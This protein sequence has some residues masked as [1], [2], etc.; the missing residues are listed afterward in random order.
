M[1]IVVNVRCMGNGMGMEIIGN[2][3]TLILALR[4][5]S[6]HSLFIFVTDR[7]PHPTVYRR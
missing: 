4:N 7:Q 2:G 6:L 3:V 5:H 1:G